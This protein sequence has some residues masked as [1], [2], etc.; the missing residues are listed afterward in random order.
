[1]TLFS[2]FTWERFLIDLLGYAAI[3][4]SVIS[5]QQKT[6]T[7]IAVFQGG[8]NLFWA[9]HMLLLA[10]Y[11]GALL[12]LVGL[13]RGILFALRGKHAWARRKIW[14]VLLLVLIGAATAFSWV[15]GDGAK[16]LLP[17]CA[18]AIT[19]FSLALR[20]PA[21]V[22]AWTSLSSPLWIAYSALAGSIPSIVAEL[23]NLTSILVGKLRLDRKKENTKE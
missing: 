11:A 21:R 18:M 17:A 14:Q 7:R 5:F 1:M 13:L 15:T 23:F 4:F 6:Q 16:A 9:T 22:R 10:A 12:N 20:D 19:T 3:A 2:A 8:S